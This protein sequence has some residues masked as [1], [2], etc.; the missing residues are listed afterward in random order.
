MV[1]ERKE[2]TF[3]GA[4]YLSQTCGIKF[5]VQQMTNVIMVLFMAL[6]L[7]VCYRVVRLF[8]FSE[9]FQA[10]VL[11]RPVIYADVQTTLAFPVYFCYVAAR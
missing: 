9:T 5:L 4:I 1:S 2:R 7:V 6:L 8:L 11:H 3:V 10:A